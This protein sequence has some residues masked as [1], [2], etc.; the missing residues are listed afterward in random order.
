MELKKKKNLQQRLKHSEDVNY[1]VRS[2]VLQVPV[3][4]LEERRQK[5]GHCAIFNPVL[6]LTTAVRESGYL[7]KGVE[8][9]LQLL[10]FPC[11]EA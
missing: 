3:F 4:N 5:M 10:L 2:N 11:V 9:P 6:F 8:E 7:D 1:F